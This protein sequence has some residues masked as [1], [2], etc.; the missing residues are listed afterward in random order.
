MI[1]VAIESN[2]QHDRTIEKSLSTC[3]RSVYRVEAMTRAE[4][5]SREQDNTCSW[6]EYRDVWL[7][8]YDSGLDI[9]HDRLMIPGPAW[10][11]SY[12]AITS[13]SGRSQN[14]ISL[15]RIWQ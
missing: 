1:T 3:T 13:S 12:S 10:H 2:E 6:D 4:S 7:T 11:L 8:T 5:L 9:A 14:E 15:F